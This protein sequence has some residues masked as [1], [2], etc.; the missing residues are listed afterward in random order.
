M[1]RSWLAQPSYPW[2]VTRNGLRLPGLVTRDMPYRNHG[3]RLPGLLTRDM[4][5]RNH[6]LRLTDLVT[7]DLSYCNHGP[8]LFNLV[9]REMSSRNHGLRLLNLVTRDM[10]CRNQIIFAITTDDSSTSFGLRSSSC[11]TDLSILFQPSQPTTMWMFSFWVTIT[12]SSST[13]Y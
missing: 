12:L 9:I 2:H 7:R 10:S 5:H 13:F 4:P 1:Y 8:R 11:R 6:G 3:L